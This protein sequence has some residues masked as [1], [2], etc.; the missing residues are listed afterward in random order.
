MRCFALL[1]VMGF[2]LGAAMVPGKAETRSFRLSAPED[3]EAT[4]FLKY[5]L[6]RF[7]AQDIHPDRNRCR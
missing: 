5:L 2:M 3:L 1:C 4:G 7:F 6:P